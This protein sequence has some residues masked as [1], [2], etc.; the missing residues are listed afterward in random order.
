[1]A[2]RRVKTARL[3]IIQCA[4][5][6]FLERGYTASSTKQIADEL[7]IGTGNLTYYFPTKEHLLAVLVDELHGFH[8]ILADRCAAEGRSSLLSY[9]LELAVIA[10]ACNESDAARDF[11]SS[12]Y[13]SPLTLE[14]IRK[15]DTERTMDIFG[16]YQ[17]KWKK[18]V[19]PL[20]L[21][22]T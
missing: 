2:R 8:S 11:Y 22:Q 19:R 17:P 10:A 1:M 15:K 16:A 3:D 20:S 6:M 21:K 14:L 4:T 18:Q 5:T 13:A 9:C 7:D 12:C